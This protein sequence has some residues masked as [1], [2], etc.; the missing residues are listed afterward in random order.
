VSLGWL[1]AY[2][3]RCL[4]NR[5]RATWKLPATELR[6]V[7]VTLNSFLDTLDGPANPPMQDL[8]RLKID[9]HV[10]TWIMERTLQGVPGLDRAC[11]VEHFCP[12]AHQECVPLADVVRTIA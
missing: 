8:V 7:E 4:L 1:A 10:C 2:P 11:R 6:F 5:Y 3:A 12:A 9:L